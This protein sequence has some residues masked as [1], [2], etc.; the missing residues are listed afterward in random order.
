MTTVGREKV[1]PLPVIL[2][3]SQAVGAIHGFQHDVSLFFQYETHQ[4]AHRFVIFDQEDCL[5]TSAQ[6]RMLPGR[7]RQLGFVNPGKIQVKS[8]P[9]T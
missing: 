9:R 1:N 8:C 6:F 2:S 5:V 3:S 7:S 4:T